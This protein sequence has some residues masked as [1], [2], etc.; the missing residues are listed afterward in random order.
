MANWNELGVFARVV[1]AGS[2]STAAADL[3]LSKAAVS[4]HVRRLEHRLGVR[5]LNR[6]TR[7][8]S[9]TAA[10][11]ACYA[12]CLRLVEE[13]ELAVRAAVALHRQPVGLL[14]ISA[15]ATFGAMHV[16]PAVAALMR[17][18]PR[19]RVDLSLSTG[20]V[21]LVKEQF[22]LAIRIGSL[23]PST[24][25]ARR[26]ATVRQI[27]TAAPEYLQRRGIPRSLDELADHDALQF[28]PLGWGAEWR[29]TAPGTRAERRVAV[30]VRFATDSGEALVAA[31][32]AG[33]GL[34]LLPNWMVH[35]E[36]ASGALVRL[37]PDWER[38]D[39]PVHAVHASGRRAPA[40]VRACV[41][42]LVRHIG[43]PPYWEV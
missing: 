14:R 5:L 16:A 25:T 42:A 39:V 20:A 30:H 32:C 6:T 17:R 23:P 40:K 12:H 19:L 24:L 34:A 9:L 13:G 7:S 4:D 38:G 18:N 3:G 35:R 10:G 43:R 31:T 29:V 11:E 36:I 8:L 21:D 28:T 37:M 22:D 2:F 15:P 27:V 1:S 41:D 26:I 33:L